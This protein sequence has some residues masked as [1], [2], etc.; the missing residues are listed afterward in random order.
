MKKRQKQKIWKQLIELVKMQLA[1]NALFV[2]TVGG[3]YIFNT[4]MGMPGF[5]AFVLAS[6]ISNIGYFFLDREWVFAEGTHKRK[7]YRD[8]LR[9]I[10][11]AV[12]NFFLNILIVGVLTDLDVNVY[13]AQVLGGVFFAIWG[14]IGLKFW[15][16]APSRHHALTIESR[17]KGR[18]YDH[19]PARPTKQKTKRTTKLH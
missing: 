8:A 18:R 19:G 2:G 15:V 1:G 12:I 13:L 4:F 14:Y 5:Q 7:G 3:T 9:F 11:F 16:F 6:V 17:R 10:I